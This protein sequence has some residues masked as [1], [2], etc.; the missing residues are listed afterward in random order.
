MTTT[1]TYKQ[2]NELEIKADLY[3][4][5]KENAPLILYIHGGGLIWGSRR[6][7]NKAQVALFNDN[8]YHVLSVSYR[9]APET[10]LPEIADDIRDALA[11]TKNGLTKQLHFNSDK[12]I[13]MGNS[14]GGYLSLLTGTFEIKPQA[15]VS[16]YGYGSVLGDWYHT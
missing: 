12:V 10:K 5:D 2:M 3:P 7:I 6:D 16:F 15:I 8:G 9:L 14:A 4:V 11:W 13:V 1:Y